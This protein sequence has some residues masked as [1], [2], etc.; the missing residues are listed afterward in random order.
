MARLRHQPSYKKEL[1]SIVGIVAV[2]GILIASLF[3]PGG[4]RDLQ[5]SRLEL[6]ARQ[7]KVDTLEIDNYRRMRN[8]EALR[9][10]P[11]AQERKARENGY[12]RENEIIQRLPE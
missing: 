2:F 8:I 11:D 3:G 7:I 5:K 10:D 4:Y 12:A 6:R 9:S 1:L